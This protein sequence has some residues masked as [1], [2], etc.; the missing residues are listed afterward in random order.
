MY[1]SS[2]WVYTMKNEKNKKSTKICAHIVVFLFALMLVPNHIGADEPTEDWPP[3]NPNPEPCVADTLEIIYA[4]DKLLGWDVGES[5]VISYGDSAPMSA[6]AQAD[7]GKVN[8]MPSTWA[9]APIEPGASIVVDHTGRMTA[10]SYDRSWTFY[11][12]LFDE[13]LN[14]VPGQDQGE[15]NVIVVGGQ[16]NGNSRVFDTR[17]CIPD[18]AQSGE[19]YYYE[20]YTYMNRIEHGA[21]TNTAIGWGKL[22]VTLDVTVPIDIITYGHMRFVDENTVDQA[23]I[24]EP[25]GD[26]ASFYM[27]KPKMTLTFNYRWETGAGLDPEES[28]VWQFVATITDLE[29][30]V[31]THSRPH[32]VIGTGVPTTSSFWQVWLEYTWAEAEA[33]KSHNIESKLEIFKNGQPYGDPIVETT[34]V[35]LFTEG[36]PE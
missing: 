2:Q 3:H 9:P 1:V 32:T 34:L 12:K 23:Y 19:I 28:N 21:G 20:I 18:D 10:G 31:K 27:H 17:V 26:P 6:R 7:W 24:D 25:Q 22:I 35:Y 30:P 16:Q 13:N 33:D 29:Y 36:P 4:N 14:L 11:L 8:S 15:V 5:E